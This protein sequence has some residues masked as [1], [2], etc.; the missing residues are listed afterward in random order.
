MRC[1][2]CGAR[3]NKN[4]SVCFKCGT[5]MSQIQHASHQAVKKARAEFEPEKV[6]YTKYFP[7]D[8]NYVKTLLM[9]IF[10]GLWGG[11]YFYVKRPI[12]GII[13]AVCWTT[14]L[15]FYLICGLNFGFVNG[16]PDFEGHKNIEL[17]SVFVAMMGALVVAYWV[18]DIIRIAM[19]RFKVPVV[20]EDK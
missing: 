9:C 12:P 20:L 2:N 7:S 5:K 10:L 19:K 3:M 17:F 15:L 4:A 8:L 1:P 6:V 11:H 18:M 13:F 14:F 16:Y